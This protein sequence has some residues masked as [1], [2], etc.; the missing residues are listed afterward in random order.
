[1]Y[2]RFIKQTKDKI[3]A[4]HEKLLVNDVL[5]IQFYSS[6]AKSWVEISSVHNKYSADIETTDMIPS[7][8][9]S[10]LRHHMRNHMRHHIEPRTSIDWQGHEINKTK[11][12]ETTNDMINS[13]VPQSILVILHVHHMKHCTAIILYNRAVT[14]FLKKSL[15]HWALSVGWNFSNLSS[16]VIICLQSSQLFLPDD[17]IH[18]RR[19]AWSTNL[20][21]PSQRHGDS[22]G[23]PDSSLLQ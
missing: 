8:R 7:M 14:L 5:W 17:S 11:A 1:M 9:H 21:E 4:Y 22:K 18:L 15:H 3:T 6:W 13:S 23:R 19:Q 20:I 10:M 16:T 12:D 2:C